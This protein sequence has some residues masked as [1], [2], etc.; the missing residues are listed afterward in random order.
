[1]KALIIGGTKGFGKEVTSSFRRREYEVITV[2][3]SC[4]ESERHYA[5]DVGIMDC[6][7]STLDRIAAEHPRLDA[8]ACVVGYARAK[9][10]DD[11]SFVDW[12]EHFN[13]NTIYV[14]LAFSKLAEVV[15][16]GRV[17]TVGSQ[18]SYKTGC[19]E[20]VPYTQAK[21]AL[22][23][24]TRDF[25][26]RE[27]IKANHF[28]VPTMDTPGYRDVRA[29]FEAMREGSFDGF[30]QELANPTSVS[31]RLVEKALTTYAAGSTFV[32]PP[33]DEVWEL[34]HPP[35]EINHMI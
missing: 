10:C 12:I 33:D 29:S 24:L 14:G 27:G 22:R 9:H 34:L 25:A 13:R 16:I 35:A 26:I 19:D 23:S 31:E 28:C 30:M 8:L 32:V 1:M 15:R 7:E 2:G 5:C 20:L 4:I 21:H 6:W 3:R 17:I 11:L 18:W